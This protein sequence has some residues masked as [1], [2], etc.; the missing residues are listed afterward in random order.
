MRSSLFF[1]GLFAVLSWQFAFLCGVPAAVLWYMKYVYAPTVYFDG[2]GK[3]EL[4]EHECKTTTDNLEDL[5]V[6][7]GATREE[8]KDLVH[9]HGAAVVRNVLTKE[10]AQALHEYT[11]RANAQL[12]D[13]EQVYVHSREHRF[14]LMPD[15]AELSVREG[16]KEIGEHSK[17]RPLID[18]LMGPSASLTGLSILTA[19][20]GS[21]D[22]DIHPD[23]TQSVVTHPDYFVPEYVVALA[24][25]DITEDMGPTQL[26]PGTHMC[27]SV[28]GDKWGED[29]LTCKVRASIKQGDA[30]IYLGDLHHRG[31]A[32]VDPEA[33]SRS[34]MFLVLTATLQSKD[35]KMYLPLGNVRSM[36][37]NMWGHTVDEFADVDKWRVWHSVGLFNKREDGLR[38]WNMLDE[39]FTIFHHEDEAAL[40][41]GNAFTAEEFD[42]LVEKVI[43]YAFIAMWAYLAIM[44]GILVYFL[45]R[46]N[47]DE[48]SD[49]SATLNGK[50]KVA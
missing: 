37:L 7:E 24:L 28:K 26:C 11:R 46:R 40:M 44:P 3:Y 29:H 42:Y 21:E 41:I 47:T 25:Q 10:T 9:M 39:I 32:H 20:Y 38:P 33:D 17:L 1:L 27:Y 6:P 22:Q 4:S 31:T 34:L 48:I 2:E 30:F 18:D 19:E 49:D 45:K 43:M 5:V 12:S 15:P 36:N 14:N 50:E 23:T 16:L 13:D 8:A 35:E